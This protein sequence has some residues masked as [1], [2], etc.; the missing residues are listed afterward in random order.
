MTE[1]VTCP[2]CGQEMTET[3]YESQHKFVCK[4]VSSS[5]EEGRES[6]SSPSPVCEILMGRVKELLA[7]IKRETEAAKRRMVELEEILKKVGNKVF[8]VKTGVLINKAELNRRK[9]R[10]LD[11]AHYNWAVLT[12]RMGENVGLAEKLNCPNY[13]VMQ[14]IH[15]IDAFSVKFELDGILKTL[16]D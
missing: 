7:E 8:D 16:T 3:F 2:N 11:D 6:L 10:I 15:D 9:R 12:D 5:P 13:E 1:Y 14:R 4:V